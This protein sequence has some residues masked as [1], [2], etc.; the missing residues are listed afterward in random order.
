MLLIT[1]LH[2]PVISHS[3]DMVSR[4][5][6]DFNMQISFIDTNLYNSLKGL[7]RSTHAMYFVA[8]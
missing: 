2:K 7:H 4:Y 5:K 3:F 8:M 1:C 6:I